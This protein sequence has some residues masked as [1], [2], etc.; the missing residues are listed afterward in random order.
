MVQ[1]WEAEQ[2]TQEN[3]WSDLYKI[4]P[5]PQRFHV[6]GSNDI[7]IVWG[8]KEIDEDRQLHIQAIQE[9]TKF[10]RFFLVGHVGGLL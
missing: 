9:R 8:L 10:P 2:K 5:F 1:R 6:C 3:S 4:L 7:H